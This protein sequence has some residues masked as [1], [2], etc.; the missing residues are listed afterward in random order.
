MPKIVTAVVDTGESDR[1]LALRK[2]RGGGRDTGD[3][4]LVDEGTR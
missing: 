1:R 2:G 4:M 3:V